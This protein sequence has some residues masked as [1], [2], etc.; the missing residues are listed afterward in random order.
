MNTRVFREEVEGETYYMP[1]HQKPPSLVMWPAALREPWPQVA[2]EHAAIPCSGAS[3]ASAVHL[4]PFSSS[5]L[6]RRE[7][8]SRRRGRCWRRKSGRR[9]K[10]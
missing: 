7:E 4:L 8:R 5:A 9:W 2:V 3:L 6:C 1:R 10:R